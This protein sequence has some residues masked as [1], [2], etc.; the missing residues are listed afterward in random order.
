[1]FWPFKKEE[2]KE[3]LPPPFEG[4]V[5]IDMDGKR[6]DYKPTK[7]ISPYDAAMLIPLFMEPR[8]HGDRFTYIRKHNLEKHFKLIKPEDEE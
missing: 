4:V 6:Y 3:D 2:P 8:M 5:F 7:T 1:M